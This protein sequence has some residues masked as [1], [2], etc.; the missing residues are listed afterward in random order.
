MSD[1]CVSAVAGGLVAKG[2]PGIGRGVYRATR[3]WRCPDHVQLS[4]EVRAVAGC[5]AARNA[6]GDAELARLHLLQ[7]RD[8]SDIWECLPRGEQREVD[9]ALEALGPAE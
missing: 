9:G 2:P 7:L 6:P 8:V 4:R 5:H 3:G 1:E